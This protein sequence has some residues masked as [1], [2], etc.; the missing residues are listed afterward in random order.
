[1]KQLSLNYRLKGE[2]KLNEELSKKLCTKN[3]YLRPPDLRL[4]G[5]I[6]KRLAGKQAGPNASQFKNIDDRKYK[7][8]TTD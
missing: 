4:D 3:Y 1:M 2:D 7:M 6:K 5:V 8:V